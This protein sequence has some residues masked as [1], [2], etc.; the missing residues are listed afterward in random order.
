MA[1]LTRELDN[2]R[3]NL[4]RHDERLVHIAD[5]CSFSE[6]MAGPLLQ[7]FPANHH[8]QTNRRILWLCLCD[9]ITQL[10]LVRTK[11]RRQIEDLADQL[12]DAG[13]PV[14]P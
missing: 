2:A 6:R 4:R 13:I 3:E 1:G 11:L 12:T 8:L 9:E 14:N 7:A 5:A 10:N